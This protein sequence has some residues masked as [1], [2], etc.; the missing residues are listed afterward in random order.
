[1][2]TIDAIGSG[3]HHSNDTRSIAVASVNLIGEKH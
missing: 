3:V 1:L 2:D